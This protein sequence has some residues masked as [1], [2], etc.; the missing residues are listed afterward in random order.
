MCEYL[1]LTGP[2]AVG[3]TATLFALQ[4]LVKKPLEIISSD[5]F[6]VYKGLDLGTAKP[7]L[8]LRA[9][10]PH[11][12]IDVCAINEQFSVA[13][14][15]KAACQLIA[16]IRNRGSIPVVCGGTVFYIKH[17]LWGLPETPIVDTALRLEIAAEL[18]R[19]GSVELHRQLSAI[20]PPS[21]LN[22]NPADTYRIC[23]ALEVW[24]SS[25]R[26]LSSF[27]RVDSV[28]TSKALLIGIGRNRAKLVE[29][30][31]KRVDSMMAA[32]L[33]DEVAGLVAQGYSITDPGMQAI[34]YRE[35]MEAGIVHGFS[36]SE[37]ELLNISD[38]IKI[39]T[40]QYA[41]RQMT[42][43]RSL[44]VQHWVEADETKQLASDIYTLAT[45]YGDD[46]LT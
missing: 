35:F 27:A 38:A 37:K 17:L 36:F 28:P 10:I 30:I 41:K 16:E 11:H 15:V 25:G 12:L 23:R 33:F 4:D 14:F 21:A 3:K 43:L 45:Q 19:I 42:F 1:V 20:D 6:Q 9:H 32:G 22:I 44:P 39:H 13:V 31:G 26:R 46:L 18:K 24:R 2:T 5:A 34:G 7:D 8:E 40:R 29:N